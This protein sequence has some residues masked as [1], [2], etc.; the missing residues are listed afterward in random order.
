MAGFTYGS[1]LR[2]MSFTLEVLT[3]LN[4]EE[5]AFR[6]M[7]SMAKKL[8]ISYYSTQT[9]AFT[10]SAIARY[11]GKNAGSG[12]SFEY[13]SGK[14]GKQTVNSAKSV[15][16]SDLDEKAGGSGSILVK[17]NNSGSKLFVNV[18]FSGQPLQGEEI[19]K[20]ENLK[21]HVSYI[22]DDGNAI[23]VGKLKQGTDFIAEVTVEHPGI[24]FNYSDL[25][26]SH[27]FPSGW[28]IINTRVQD[29]NSAMKEDQ[30]DYRDYRDDRVYTFFKLNQYEKKT[31]RVRLNAAYTGRYY[32]PAVTCES[33][34]ES[35]IQANTQG[36]WVEVVR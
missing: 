8:K 25:A 5:E 27:V 4:K 11:V 24:L 22:D 28:E 29:I 26:L 21:M 16:L 7:E 19:E 2:D 14:T 6:L 15:Y 12:L 23:N 36:R 30:F 20:F 33:M 18:C 3:M 10:L 35:N 13:T 34:Y 31:F 32:L 17:N 1:E 9:A